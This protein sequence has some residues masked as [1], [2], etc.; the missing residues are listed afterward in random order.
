MDAWL[1]N[2]SQS[3]RTGEKLNADTLT[4][5]SGVYMI[6]SNIAH[7]CIKFSHKLVI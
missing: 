5:G 1:G 6:I 2:N 7:H 4:Y 3:M